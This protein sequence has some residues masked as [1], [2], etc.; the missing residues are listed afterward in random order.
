MLMKYTCRLCDATV[1]DY[2]EALKHF[3][4]WHGDVLEAFIEGFFEVRENE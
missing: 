3:F 1:E 4:R 2:F